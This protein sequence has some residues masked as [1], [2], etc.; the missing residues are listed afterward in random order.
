MIIFDYKSIK[1]FTNQQGLKGR[2]AR[3][4]EIL[5]EYDA[6]LWYYQGQYNIVVDALSRMP[7][8]N[9]LLFMEIKS[10]FL[11]SLKGKYEHDKAYSKV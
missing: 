11:A 10:D 3:W 5:Q 8:I 2:K 4:A 1:W 9:S 7:K 6:Q